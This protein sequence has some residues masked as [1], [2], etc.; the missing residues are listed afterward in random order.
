[1]IRRRRVAAADVSDDGRRRR[2]QPTEA[3]RCAAQQRVGRGQFGGQHHGVAGDALIGVGVHGGHAAAGALQSGDRRAVAE[4]DS[5]VGGGRGQRIGQC[6]HA[7][8][9]KV[10][11]GDGVHVGDHRVHRQCA[12]RRHSGVQ[13]LEG[14][15]SPQPLVG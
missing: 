11:P 6:P 15:D 12:L 4:T 2:P 9:R 1:M 13:R 10:H 5:G 3:T 7:A 14:E 8:A